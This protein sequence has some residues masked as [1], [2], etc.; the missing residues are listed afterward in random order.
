[1]SFLRLIL[2]AGV[3]PLTTKMATHDDDDRRRESRCTECGYGV[4][5]SR[6]PDRCPMCGGSAWSADE[7][8]GRRPAALAWKEQRWA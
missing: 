8:G 7:P 5:V 1:M 6:A 4:V 3:A 2:T